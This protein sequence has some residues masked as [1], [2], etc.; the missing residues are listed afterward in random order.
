MVSKL[1]D[2]RQK[3]VKSLRML[4]ITHREF[5]LLL[6]FGCEVGGG[7]VGNGVLFGKTGGAVGGDC[8]YCCQNEY[9]ISVR[10]ML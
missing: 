10:Y 5:F 4:K 9:N 2:R 8:I 7:V 3:G 6:T 1:F